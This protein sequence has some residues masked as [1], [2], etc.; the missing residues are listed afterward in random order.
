MKKVLLISMPFGALERQA[1][2]I[3]L[4]KARLTE[5]DILCDIRYLTFP[6][7]EYIGFDEYRWMSFELPY[8]AFVGDWVFTGALYGERPEAAER[9]IQEIL[10]DTWRLDETVI[11]QIRRVRA[12]VPHFLA[13]CLAA[14]PWH[15]YAMVGF[16]ST[17]EQNIASLALARQVKVANPN[18]AIVF[19]GANW[20]GEM[21]LELHRQ[22]PF[23]DYACSG[24]ADESFPMLVRCVLAGEADGGDH[25]IP[26]VIYR[27]QGESVATGQAE[28][29]RRMD[30]LPVPDYSDYFR[31][32]E[33][34][35]VAASVAPILLLE[36]ARGC[37]WGAKSH[38]TFCGL[39]GSTLTFRSKSPQ[40]ALDELEHLADRWQI[41]YVEVVDNILDMKYFQTVL[42]TLARAQRPLSLFYEVKAD[43]ARKHLRALRAAGVRRIQPGIES[44]SDHILQLMRKGTTA[45]QNIQLMKW[46]HE[47]NICAE[48]NILYGFPGE[49]CTDYDAML[50]LLRAIRFLRPPTG[51]GPIRLDRFS[52][53]F[54]SPAAYGFV[55]VRPLAPYPHLYPFGQA[56]LQRI[57]YYF[58]YDYAPGIDPTGYA[59]EVIAFVHAWKENP[60]RGMLLSVVGQDGALVVVNTR[61]NAV[62][63][64]WRFA[65]PEQAAYTFCDEYH[66][67][68][69]VLQYLRAK[70]PEQDFTQQAVLALLDTFVANQL[71]VTDG[72]HY[73]SLA[74]ATEPVK[75]PVEQAHLHP[76][77]LSAT[78]PAPPASSYLLPEFDLVQS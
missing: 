23:V 2:G 17:F 74:V 78:M 63:A 3:S 1:L 4:L 20:E 16:T 77:A 12:L 51:C 65:G 18:I 6:F 42:P 75:T 67:A 62:Q 41:D 21:G 72:V 8:T 40:R 7:A 10:R 64:N 22:F 15:E 32:L 47:Y 38:C 28:L 70:F 29:L 35:T 27:A 31:D 50:K 44:L 58:E 53:Y 52:P 61:G 59:A 37:W 54:D 9:Y 30:D 69:A 19:G 56:V 24:E 71:M 33:E 36:T 11:N 13:Y 25:P 45:L 60:E 34:S 39:N 49:T 14:V 46:A 26:G 76:A 73:L 68:A 5:Q 43:L 48:W 57:A 55:N 66:T